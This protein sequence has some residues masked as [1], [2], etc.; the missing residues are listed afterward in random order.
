MQHL[1]SLDVIKV[2]KKS[3]KAN[4]QNPLGSDSKYNEILEKLQKLCTKAGE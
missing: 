3:E 1:Y 2:A 4:K